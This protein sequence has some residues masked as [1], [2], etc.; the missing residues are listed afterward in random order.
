MNITLG[1]GVDEPCLYVT[2][3]AEYCV[4]ING[5]DY[6][7]VS[8]LEPD[9]IRVQEWDEAFQLGKGPVKFIPMEQ[10]DSIHIY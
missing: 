2:V 6:Y 10:I 8:E 5:V 4:A 1:D 7:T 3:P 9:G